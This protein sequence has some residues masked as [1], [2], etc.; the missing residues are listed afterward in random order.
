MIFGA[1][2]IAWL[3]YLVPHFVR[4]REEE[5]VVDEADPASRFSESM[6]IVR[7]GTAP[8]L[9]QDLSP[10]AEYEVSTPLTRRAAIHELR[11]LEQVAASRRRRVLL[12]LLALLSATVAVAA[13]GLVPWGLVLVPGALLVAFLAVARVSVRALRRELDARFARVRR[14]SDTES[15]VRL[16]RKDLVAATSAPAKALTTAS[17]SSALWDPVP[18]TVPTYVSKPLAPR[19]VRTIDLSGPGVASSTRHDG[20]VTADAPAAPVRAARSDVEDDGR[21]AAAS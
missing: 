3:A 8:L 13:L 14:G 7:H 20:P 19:T 6:R 5:L 2:A 18:I 9:N 12:V 10:I 15:T 21:Q 4:R 1:I 17:A 11:R 16:S